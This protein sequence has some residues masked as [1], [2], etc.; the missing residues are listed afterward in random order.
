[1]KK[2][3][4]CSTIISSY[5][6]VKKIIQ[7]HKDLCS[8]LADKKLKQSLDILKL[9]VDSTS[10]G[11]LISEHENI[12]AVYRNMLTY[13]IQGIIDPERN[14][15][16]LKLVLSTFTIADKARQLLLSKHSG[17]NT[18]W[19]KIQTEKEQRLSDKSIVETVDDLIF[20]SELDELLYPEKEADNIP[21]SEGFLKHKQ[22]IKSIFNHLWLTDY[23]GEAEES[24]MKIILNSGKFQWY[25]KSIFTS[26]VTLSLFRVWQPVKIEEL[27]NIYTI[28]EA[29]VMERAMTGLVLNLHYYDNRIQFYPEIISRIKSL[30]QDDKYRRHYKITVLQLIRSKETERLSKKLRDEIIPQM[31]KLTPKIDEKLNLE[32]ILSA[33]IKEGKNPDWEAMLGES[34]Q[35]F[36]TMEELTKLQMEGADIYLSA[37]ANLKNFDF[38]NEI[39][40][41]FLPFYPDHEILNEVFKDDIL[42]PGTNELAEVMYKTPYI[43]NS[44]KYSLVYNMKYLPA[45][46]KSMMLKVFKMELE[47]LQKMNYEN[48]SL[49]DPDSSF[50]RNITQYIQD[51]YRFFTLSPNKREFENIFSGK[52]DIYNS[53]SF[54]LICSDPEEEC[55]F[56]DYFFDKNFHDDALVLLLKYSA[57]HPDDAQLYEKIGYCYQELFNITEALK[58]YRRA[59]LIDRKVWT[60]KKIGLCLRRLG[61]TEEAL[62]YY[63]QAGDMEPD[64]IHTIMMIGHC[65]L[66][67]KEYENALTYYFKVEYSNPNNIKILRPI[68]YCYLALSRFDDSEKYYQR[69]SAEKLSAHDL[70]NIGHLALCQEKLED[71]VEYY[72]Q[73]ITNGEINKEQFISFFND[74]KTLLMSLGINNDNLQLILDYLYYI[75]D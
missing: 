51:L 62:E 56:A 21:G 65:Y 69:L 1:M 72:R 31:A 57:K 73:S 33:D 20:K 49:A 25:E 50:R 75:I 53:L 23:Y 46:Q 11:E 70:I 58:Y 43:C 66:D 14:N 59:E 28:G 8:L 42:G 45:S 36:K 16:Y 27:F 68:A 3:I 60:L 5:M 15:I 18:Y 74:D 35:I 40:N 52:L 54:R 17:W 41:W 67:M 24:L 30:A 39:L 44:D 19:V 9:L 26:A 64:N 12:V 10:S 32:N 55:L 2:Y 48:S 7:L 38:F 4:L 63:I 22:L 47:G 37:F 13:N 71:A 34:E 29:Q 6:E 61:K